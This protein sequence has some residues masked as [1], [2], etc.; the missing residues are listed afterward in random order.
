MIMKAFVFKQYGPP[1]QVLHPEDIPKPKPGEHEVLVKVHATAIN[2]YDWS[3]VRGKPDIYRLFYGLTKPKHQIPGMELAGVV[4]EIGSAVE[5]F[6]VGDEVYSDTSEFGFGTFA[7]YVCVNEK[8][9]IPKPKKISFEVSIH[10]GGSWG[11]VF[12]PAMLDSR[13]AS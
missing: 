13:V 5:G 7:E 2:D 6:E 3:M 4:E 12:R 1:E 11:R 10:K 8:A 9:V